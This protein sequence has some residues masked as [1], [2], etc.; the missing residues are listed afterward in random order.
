MPNIIEL[1]TEERSKP[2]SFDA[3]MDTVEGLLADCDATEQLDEEQELADIIT[4]RPKAVA[5]DHSSN[6]WL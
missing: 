3:L 2:Q 5:V 6:E 4:W 1:A